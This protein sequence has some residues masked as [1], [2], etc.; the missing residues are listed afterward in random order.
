MSSPPTP[1]ALW[2]IIVGLAVGSFLLRFVFLGMIGSRTMPAWLLRHLRYTGVAILPALVTPAVLWPA[3]TGG[4]PDLPRLA[5]AGATIM[6]GWLSR[7]VL[8]AILAGAATLY[9]LLYLLG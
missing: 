7:S 3:A 1:L 5:A 6:A 2:T 4:A 8:I 9:G